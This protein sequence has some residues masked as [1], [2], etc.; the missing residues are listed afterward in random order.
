MSSTSTGHSHLPNPYETLPLG[1]E[2]PDSAAEGGNNSTT[3]GDESVVAVKETPKKAPNFKPYE[4]VLLAKAY[5]NVSTDPVNGTD[6]KSEVFWS[7]IL[8][9]YNYLMRQL[10]K[11]QHISGTAYTEQ[12][13]AVV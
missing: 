8:S 13:G 2:E 9:K 3:S 10:P 7:N 5:A 12:G 11:S 4:D 1:E 6:Q